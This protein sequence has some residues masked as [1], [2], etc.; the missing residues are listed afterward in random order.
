MNNS[1]Y[2]NLITNVDR[3]SRREPSDP[4]SAGA[5]LERKAAL[6]ESGDSTSKFNRFCFA[7]LLRRECG[8]RRRGSIRNRR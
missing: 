3:Y 2:F 1:F 4:N 6:G 7:C 5:I 8:N